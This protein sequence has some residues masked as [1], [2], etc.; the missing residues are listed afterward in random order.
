MAVTTLQTNLRELVHGQY[1]TAGAWGHTTTYGENNNDNNK[2]Y[3]GGE[4]GHYRSR[5][6]FTV[7]SD[8]DLTVSSK[9]VIEMKNWNQNGGALWTART[10][11]YL[12]TT[13]TP[14]SD[15]TYLP[16]LENPVLSYLYSDA[17]GTNRITGKFSCGSSTACYL[18]FN[19]TNIKP[20]QTYYI[21]IT[22]Y[23]S[24]SAAA[25]QQSWTNTWM[26]WQNNPDGN[27]R[28]NAYLY[29]TSTYTVSFNSNGG[30]TAPASITVDKGSS[31]TLPAAPSA[32]NGYHANS[33]VWGGSYAAGASYTP[34]ANVT[35]TASWVANTYSV[36]YNGNGATSG[37]MSNSS[38]TYN[39]AKNLTSNG[40]SK[41]NDIDYYDHT[42]AYLS[43]TLVEHPFAFW[44]TKSGGT[45][46]SYA[47]QASVKNL[48]STNGATVNLYAQWNS[49]TATLIVPAAREGYIFRGW[50][51]SLGGAV[52]YQGGDKISPT[53]DLTLYAV[54][55]Q[56][57]AGVGTLVYVKANGVWVQSSK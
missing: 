25:N 45:G 27:N 16:S 23:A 34:T 17:N 38:H 14:T 56:L 6:Y 24:D 28:L 32:P 20:G 3:V 4:D 35:L 47:N 50:S 18:I 8:L 9:L 44:N 7:P 39:T 52:S 33:K 36:K 42:G 15:T 53:S 5:L 40:F 29:Y 13:N 11:G 26:E 48:T 12:S 51:T 49:G 1:G 43:S 10:R 30:G 2:F 21:Y 46:T 37:S 54:Y 31:I 57:T 22:P 19:T 55:Q 41:S